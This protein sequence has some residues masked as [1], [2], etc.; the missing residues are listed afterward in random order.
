M[1]RVKL[2]FDK[3]DTTTVGGPNATMHSNSQASCIVER[4]NSV[5]K[6]PNDLTNQAR[7][8]TCTCAHTIICVLGCMSSLTQFKMATKIR[9]S[10]TYA[11]STQSICESLNSVET[12]LICCCR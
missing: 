4:R 8:S 1:E 10:L 7:C 12:M 11:E 6:S 9:L 3:Q 5:E 2:D